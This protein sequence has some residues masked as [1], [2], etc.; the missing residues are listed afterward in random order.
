MV[1]DFFLII[2]LGFWF[3]LQFLGINLLPDDSVSDILCTLSEQRWVNLDR[4]GEFVLTGVE[5]LHCSWI[6]FIFLL[7]L[8]GVHASNSWSVDT[9]LLDD[10]VIELE[11]PGED[12]FFRGRTEFVLLLELGESVIVRLVRVVAWL[13]RLPLARLKQRLLI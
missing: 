5:V 13:S 7:D 11:A 10:L 8:R 12:F 6:S 3:P 2:C 4:K 1:Q 9:R